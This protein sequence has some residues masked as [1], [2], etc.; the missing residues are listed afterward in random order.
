MIF[1]SPN[2]PWFSL[3]WK[4]PAPT[5][6]AH[7]LHSTLKTSSAVSENTA[8]PQTP[9]VL[10]EADQDSNHLLM[11]PFLLLV[12]KILL[13]KPSMS[14]SRVY[15]TCQ[16]HSRSAISTCFTRYQDGLRAGQ[17]YGA[18]GIGWEGPI[19]SYPAGRSWNITDHIMEH[20]KS[21]LKQN[22]ANKGQNWIET[23]Q[24]HLWFLGFLKSWL[25]T[26]KFNSNGAEAESEG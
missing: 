25:K 9:L 20:V 4:R 16:S 24:P 23:K 5:S 6:P 7:D 15:M 2:T 3:C 22:T 13:N 11:R 17:A 21:I 26:K 18:L 10:V 1:S 8:Y 14:W 12:W 19:S